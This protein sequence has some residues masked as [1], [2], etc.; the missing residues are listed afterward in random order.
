MQ[1]NA[2]QLQKIFSLQRNLQKKLGN[3]NLVGNQEFIN[4]MSLALIDEVMESLRETPYKP[5]K[6]NQAF[7]QEKYKEEI[8][9]AWHFLINLTLA[10]GMTSNELYTKFAHKNKVNHE[11][12]KTGY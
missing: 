9:D 2:D 4:M 12:Q 1:K 10:S 3:K 5:W 11:R 7:N 6:K 8:V